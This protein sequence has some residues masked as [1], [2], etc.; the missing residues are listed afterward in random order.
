MNKGIISNQRFYCDHLGASEQ[1]KKDI[2]SFTVRHPEV[3]EGL[4]DYIRE[5]AFQDEENGLMRSYLVRDLK[6]DELVGYFSLKAGMVSINERRI[7]DESGEERTEFDTVPGIE[8]AN[9][10]LNESYCARHTKVSGLGIL[11]FREFI[12]KLA[13]RTARMVG[14]LM[15][16]IFA[17]PYDSLIRRYHEVYRFERLN[18]ESESALHTR[19]KPAYDESCIFMYQML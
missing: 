13:Y 18:K 14:V 15:L 9:F 11:I 1:D 16:Y 19:M 12:Q 4:R 6:T 10:A 7:V 17:L 2:L 3:A 8:I 5:W